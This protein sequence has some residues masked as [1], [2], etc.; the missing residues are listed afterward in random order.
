MS[1]ESAFDDPRKWNWGPPATFGDL[2]RQYEAA[3]DERGLPIKDKRS[4]DLLLSTHCHPHIAAL[5]NAARSRWGNNFDEAKADKV[6]E[7]FLVGATGKNVPEIERMLIVKEVIPLV[8]RKEKRTGKK[9]RATSERK[10]RP[11]TA[12]QIEALTLCSEHK[13]NKAKC[14]ATMGISRAA[15]AKHLDRAYKKL[16]QVHAKKIKM[17]RL[18]QDSRDQVDLASAHDSRARRTPGRNLAT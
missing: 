8:A 12:K 9:R 2:K 17:Q 4:R 5:R 7:D 11:L 10:L 18:P 3:R 13:G 15:F 14:A 1:S 16:G 6:I